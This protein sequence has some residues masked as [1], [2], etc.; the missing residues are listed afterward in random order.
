MKIT[1]F[2]PDA[3]M[4]SR[5]RSGWVRYVNRAYHIAISAPAAWTYHSLTWQGYPSIELYSPDESAMPLGEPYKNSGRARIVVSID[6]AGA[7]D[8]LRDYSMTSLE[9]MERSGTD[10]ERPFYDPFHDCSDPRPR[11]VIKRYTANH[12]MGVRTTFTSKCEWTDRFVFISNVDHN[13]L[14]FSI[15]IVVDPYSGQMTVSHYVRLFDEV[16]D[17]L[18]VTSSESPAL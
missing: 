17:T 10:G 1:E 13:P 12:T 5:Y 4:S 16:L 11:R 2:V 18:E 7:Y 3:S 8:T 14:L 6:N 15:G 9:Q